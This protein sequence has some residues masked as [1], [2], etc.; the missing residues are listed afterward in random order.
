MLTG[1][2]KTVAAVFGLGG[3]GAEARY[4]AEL[5]HYESLSS[6][7]D[8][9]ISRQKELLDGSVGAE[10]ITHY[11]EALDNL[12]KQ[13]EAALKKL[14]AWGDTKK[15]SSG[16]TYWARERRYIDNYDNQKQL[17]DLLGVDVNGM[18]GLLSLSSDQLK[19]IQEKMPSFYAGLFD[20]T[21]EYI[22]LI[23]ESEEEAI[24]LQDS[25]NEALTG[26]T[27]DEAKNS[28][29]DLLMS[30]DTTMDNIANNFEDYMRNAIMNIL[31]ENIMSDKL[32]SW[33][34]RF[35]SAMDDDTLTIN[36]RQ[37]LQ[38]EYNSIVEEAIKK[39]DD[40]LGI[41]GLELDNSSSKQQSSKG[42]ATT[43]S[44]ETGSAIEGRLTGIQMTTINI[45]NKLSQ[46]IV[47]DQ[48]K[49][50]QM[51]GMMSVFHSLVDIQVQSMWHLESIVSNT[52]HLVNISAGINDMKNL[53]K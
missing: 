6:V 41:A 32:K 18:N 4:Q 24:K 13:Q 16:R 11:R 52:K 26:I 34:E 3:N 35:A 23:I 14:N 25:L 30:A 51:R 48:E 27:F 47:F 43:I 1:L 46:I 7:L 8:K 49:L 40:L 36:E 39:R 50:T 10:S 28:L 31:V 37:S 12:E 9:I 20:E 44:Q 22:E 21:R 33:Y 29:K 42:S 17:K 45:D 38:D 19:L 53:L 15:N 5:A 2:G